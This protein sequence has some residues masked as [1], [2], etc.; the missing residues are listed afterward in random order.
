VFVYNAYRA[1]GAQRHHALAKPERVADARIAGPVRA[2]GAVLGGSGEVF[3]IY[4]ITPE[5]EFSSCAGG[6]AGRLGRVHQA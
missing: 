4:R 6:E 2:P 5:L 3:E 1:A